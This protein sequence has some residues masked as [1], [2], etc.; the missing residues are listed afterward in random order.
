VPSEWTLS[1]RVLSRVWSRF[2]K[3]MVDLF[4]TRFSRRLPIFVSPVPDDYAWAVDAMA[5]D[6]TGL[7]AYALPPLP[8]LERVL[9]KAELERPRLIIL[10]S[11][12]GR[13]GFQICFD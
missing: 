3:P 7:E 9:R 12:R 2:F 4:A 10:L 1:F 8:M 11:G 6:W 13:P 5:I